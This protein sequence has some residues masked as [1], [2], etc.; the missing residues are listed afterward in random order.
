MIEAAA[1]RNAAYVEAGK[2]EF[3][4]GSLEDVDLGKRRFDVIFAVR[5]RLFHSE[6]ERAL[7]L[8]ERSLAP[9]GRVPT[10]FDPPARR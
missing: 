2:A 4:V 7:A 3:L 9:G 10:F 8:A 1:A 5:V 6:P